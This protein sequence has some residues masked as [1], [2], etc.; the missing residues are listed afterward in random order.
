MIEQIQKF[1]KGGGTSRQQL[2]ASKGRFEAAYETASDEARQKA[3]ALIQSASNYTSA[4]PTVGRNN[5]LNQAQVYDE[6]T[7]IL[8]GEGQ[9]Q[10]PS[11]DNGWGNKVINDFYAINKNRAQKTTPSQSAGQFTKYGSYDSNYF[12]ITDDSWDL[13]ARVNALAEKIMTSLDNAKASIDSG[14]RIPGWSLEKIN[15]LQTYLSNA[16]TNHAND[17]RGLQAAILRKDKDF[18]ITDKASWDEYFGETDDLTPSERNWGALKNQGYTKH[19]TANAPEWLKS[20]L[21]KNPN[22][23]FAEK[24]GQIMAFNKDWSEY[25]GGAF[26]RINLNQGDHYG[27]GL[28]IDAA[29]RTYM[30]STADITDQHWANDMYQAAK[31]RLSDKYNPVFT[32]KR[33][34]LLNDYSDSNL[35]NEYIKQLES[36]GYSNPD[37][38]YTDVSKLFNGTAGVIAYNPDGS[39]LTTGTFGELQISPNTV[40]MWQNGDGSFGSGTLEQAKQALGGFKL[41]GYDSEANEQLGAISDLSRVFEGA[42]GL[43]RDTKLRQTNWKHALAAGA[44]GAT[45]GGVVGGTIGSSA[46][47]IGAIPGW[48]VGAIGGFLT[49]AGADLIAQF[50][51]NDTIANKP[52]AFVDAAMQ[53]LKDP[54]KKID[55]DGIAD[56]GMTGSEFMAQFGSRTDLLETIGSFLQNAEVTLS[57]ADQRYLQNLYY[58]INK[59]RLDSESKTR[60]HQ[61]GGILFA[62]DGTSLF[63][64]A[65]RDVNNWHTKFDKTKQ[66]AKEDQDIE[67]A[68]A[69]GYKNA[70]HYRANKSTDL[71]LTDYMRFATMAQDAAS[72]VASFVP[73][74][75]TGVAAGLGVT[76]MGTDLV[77]D[78]LDPAVSA[79][80]VVKNLGMNAAF[81]GMGLIPGAKMGKVAKNIVKYAPKIMTAVAGLGIAMDESTQATFKKIGDGSV[82]FNREDWRNI[83]H[84]LSLLAGATRGVR[85][86]AANRKVKNSI[87]ASDNVKLKGVKTADGKD[88]ELPKQTVKDINAELAKANTP[89]DIKAIQQKYNNLPDEAIDAPIIKEGKLAGKYKLVGTES[90]ADANKTYDSMRALWNAD[91]KALKEQSKTSLGRA[92]IRFANTFGGGAYGANQRAMLSEGLGKLQSL[93]YDKYNPLVD[94]QR[95]RTKSGMETISARP[96]T[97]EQFSHVGAEAQNAH[98]KELADFANLRRKEMLEKAGV[99]EI[100][101]QIRENNEGIAG[102]S[103][104]IEGNE[105]GIA[106]AKN[107]IDEANIEL[108]KLIHQERMLK[109]EPRLAKSALSKAKRKLAKAVSDAERVLGGPLTLGKDG[110]YANKRTYTKQQKE[111]IARLNNLIQKRNEAQKRVDSIP[112][113]Q[114]ELQLNK[115]SIQDRIKSYQK[116]IDDLTNEQLGGIRQLQR[117]E[118]LRDS[119]S[120]ENELRVRQRRAA[121][122]NDK[123]QSEINSKGMKLEGEVNSNIRISG[124]TIKKGA[125]IT[126][127]E[128][129]RTPKAMPPTGFNTLD[130]KRV[131]EMFPNLSNLRGAA[132]NPSTNEIVIWE[133]GGQ[134]QSKFSHLR[135]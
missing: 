102:L 38:S 99:N 118:A 63:T 10:A 129:L 87:V 74:A 81:A 22:L 30:G 70:E 26:D 116:Q 79:G 12:G 85:Q 68:K 37:T 73:G 3:S 93:K 111:V 71:G 123:I 36:K 131:E 76:S 92:A 78:I 8:R 9:S 11:I 133:K 27:Y 55:V 4:N 97:Q 34:N 7:R 119:G 83:S 61:E 52:Q 57:P 117:R 14:V 24:D 18:G 89:D 41:E 109:K 91:A 127:Y 31:K 15:N 45:A 98:R 48:L 33:F 59:E 16:I 19:D 6:A 13:N 132:Y 5:R 94:W 44:S 17:P 1:S 46:F 43:D 82:K 134:I 40:F 125:T 2:N 50:Y 35:V 23:Q 54:S 72:I 122:M 58:T 28:L 115:Q 108:G 29:G 56:L 114:Q 20:I 121:L 77:A 100:E 90:T 51:N 49:G 32:R 113:S 128:H 66:L 106:A 103:K 65:P 75:G 69:E 124:Q 101:A 120:L 80:E 42:E 84:V 126:S 110:S 86:S 130:L 25:T 112:G 21:S 67:K 64:N 88:F 107:S 47:G 105:S 62:A 104:A 96:V 60:K 135:K 95:L 53:A 39:E